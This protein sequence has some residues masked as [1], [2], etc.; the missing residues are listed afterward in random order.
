[1]RVMSVVACP[2]LSAL[3]IHAYDGSHLEAR[4]AYV[5][6]RDAYLE[7]REAYIEKLN[8]LRA[9]DSYFE[10]RDAERGSVPSLIKQ[11]CVG[12]PG[13]PLVAA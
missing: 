10:P 4:D 9:R 2:L 5:E 11:P 1:M 13:S 3:P 6:A 7:A 12:S 8:G